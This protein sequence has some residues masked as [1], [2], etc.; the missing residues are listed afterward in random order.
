MPRIAILEEF[1]GRGPK[2]ARKGTRAKRSGG[3]K[4][5]FRAQQKKMKI[6]A[7][8]CKRTGRYLKCMSVCLKKGHK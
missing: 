5:A 3:G 1:F 4:G 2:R 8:K 6:C 7:K